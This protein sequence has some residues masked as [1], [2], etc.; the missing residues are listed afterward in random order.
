MQTSEHGDQCRHC[1]R[2]QADDSSGGE[3][4]HRREVTAGGGERG[5]N[6][7]D[8]NRHQHRQQGMFV[9]YRM[10]DGGVD[11]VYPS[12]YTSSYIKWSSGVSDNVCCSA[13][14]VCES[15]CCWINKY[16]SSAN[17]FLY[18]LSFVPVI[19]LALSLL[20][21]ARVLINSMKGEYKEDLVKLISDSRKLCWRGDCVSTMYHRLLLPFKI[22]FL[23]LLLSCL[24]DLNFFFDCWFRD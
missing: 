20:P 6:S 2:R 12:V 8:S 24:S 23:H 5:S 16:L 1:I 21:L 13:S 17:S 4:S 18:F 7:Y 11:R 15:T 14:G 19:L 22:F 10:M 3:L 9:I